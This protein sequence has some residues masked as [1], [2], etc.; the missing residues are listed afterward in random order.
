MTKSTPHHAFAYTPSDSDEDAG[1]S[2]VLSHSIASVVSTQKK[3][4]ERIFAKP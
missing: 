4:S 1:H 2:A 3:R